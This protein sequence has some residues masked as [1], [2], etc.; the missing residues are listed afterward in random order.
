MTR[1]TIMA[2]FLFLGVS[3]F[4]GVHLAAATNQLDTRLVSHPNEITRQ[5][6]INAEIRLE[7]QLKTYCDAQIFKHIDEKV[8]QTEAAFEKK[9]HNQ[10]TT[11]NSL[12]KSAKDSFD[13]LIRCA[14]WLVALFT[15]LI[16]VMAGIAGTL[17]WK[18]DKTLREKFENHLNEINTLQNRVEQLNGE[19]KEKL[20][21][22]ET[23]KRD[24]EF[25]L[26]EHRRINKELQPIIAYRDKKIVWAFEVKGVK[27]TQEI[28]EIR[29]QGFKNVSECAPGE[30]EN[31]S[32]S[33]CDCLIYYY[34]NTLTAE[35]RLEEILS[36]LKAFDRPVPLIIYTY[37]N[38]I[39]PEQMALL[40]DFRNYIISNMPLTLI[41]HLNSLIRN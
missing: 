16:A 27:A 23:L 32:S 28:E 31:L 26:T 30:E 6:S 40:K 39:A 24:Y 17:F 38:R 5:E 25:A 37:P 20:A 34:R 14:G 35:Q 22:L 11:L 2:L 1:Y 9:W 29:N 12:Y 33:D 10:F 15:T 18:K 41:S 4:S 3:C 21:E 36:A 8:R 19:F 7:K 13:R